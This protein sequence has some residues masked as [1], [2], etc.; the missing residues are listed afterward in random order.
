MWEEKEGGI[1]D[2]GWSIVL[3]TWVVLRRKRKGLRGKDD[4]DLLI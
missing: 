3:D 4:V 2:C 1:K